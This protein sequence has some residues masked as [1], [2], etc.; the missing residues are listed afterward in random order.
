M[1]ALLTKGKS[2]GEKPQTPQPTQHSGT[3]IYFAWPP[4]GQPIVS[5]GEDETAR[6]WD[7]GTGEL[8]SVQPLKA[9]VQCAAWSV[10][11]QTTATGDWEGR[12]KIRDVGTLRET[13]IGQHLAVSTVQLGPSGEHLAAG[14]WESQVNIWGMDGQK[15]S[16]VKSSENPLNLGHRQRSRLRFGPGVRLL[17]EDRGLLVG[18]RPER[19]DQVLVSRVQFT[20]GPFPKHIL[21]G[22]LRR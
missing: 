1:P 7:T 2:P 10:D 19:E 6:L 5:T 8:Q 3:V 13:L 14:S 17:H 4:D 18:Y 9:M 15:R 20:E 16:I 12:M 21:R 11:V 22:Y